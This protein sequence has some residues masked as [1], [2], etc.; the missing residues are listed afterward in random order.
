MLRHIG[1]EVFLRGFNGVDPV[2]PIREAVASGHG[3]G[4]ST[5]VAWLV[6]WLMSTRPGCK[7]TVTAN[8]VTQ[9]ETKTWPAIDHWTRLCAT[10]PWFILGTKSIRA[11]KDPRNWFFV[12]QTAREENSEAFA[13]QHAATS[14]SCYIFD[15][16]SAVPDA[17]WEVAEGG[18]TDGEPHI[19]AFGNPT[20]NSGK[21]YRI[22]FGNE[23]HRWHHRSIDSRTAARSNKA[24]IAEWI[25]DY[26]IDSDFVRVRV[27]GLPPAASEL[28]FIDFSRVQEARL[29]RVETLA[30]EPLIAGFD[31][32]GGGAAWNVIRFRRGLDGRSIPPIRIPGEK[33]RD[34]SVLIGVAAAVL[35]ESTA[36]KKGAAMFVDSAFGAPI[37]KRLRT[38]GFDNVHEVS[39]GGPSPDY[40]DANWRAYMWR[41]M[42]DW[43]AKGAIPDEEQLALQIC[44]PAIINR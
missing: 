35:R 19:F 10:R 40:H 14:S 43:L 32:S 23:S 24:Q 3:I 7:G 22:T 26:G 2:A 6:D 25:S 37:V 39:F 15:E 11:I 8:T 16:A 4:K 29:R 42:K 36:E 9:L 17:I 28:Q 27:L 30:D 20:R 5:M 12:A 41:Q 33:G 13:G 21:F 18:L 38:L 1:R 44:L 31:V 34:R